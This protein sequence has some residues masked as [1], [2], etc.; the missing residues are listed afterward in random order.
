MNTGQQTAALQ[1]CSAIAWCVAATAWA[2][3][4]PKPRQARPTSWP[5]EVASVFFADAREHLIGAQPEKAIV[6][7]PGDAGAAHPEP[8]VDAATSASWSQVIDA[9]TLATEVKRIA[10]RLHEPLASAARFKAGGFKQ[11]RS[12]FGQLA[13]LFGVIAQYD[14]DV[15]WRDDAAA[16]RDAFTQASRG[17]EAGTDQTFARAV[18]R[19]NALDEIVRG[20]KA[21]GEASAKIDDW[22]S[23][24]DRSI[25]MF[26]M[27]TAWR[28]NVSPELSDTKRFGKSVED[29]RHEAQLLAMLAAV[30][31][32][33]DFEYWD[34]ETFIDYARQ[35]QDAST[36]LSRAATDGNYEAARQSSGRIGQACAA[37]HD[38]YRG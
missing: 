18:E 16:L 21:A 2:A 33:Q 9:D 12:D 25:L 4:S 8:G 24:A 3:E 14:G 35:L 27:Q 1:A 34:D 26:R 29:I 37:C 30:I 15:R 5:P 13:V 10:A 32:R 38:G 17:C 7:N 11:C 23:L 31:H 28:D 22:S 19:M 6:G 36:A 20:G